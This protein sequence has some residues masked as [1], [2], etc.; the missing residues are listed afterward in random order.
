L[1]RLLGD[2]LIIPG[3]IMQ[4]SIGDKIKD[5]RKLTGRKQEDLANA[6]GVTPQAVSRW[7]ANGGYPDIEMIPSIANYFHIT[8]D[9]LFGYNNDRDRIIQ[10][11]NDK[12]QA[13]INKNDD[14]TECIALIRKGLEEFPDRVDFKT[15]LAHA[16]NMQGW[17]KNGEVPNIFWEEAAKLYE[18]LLAH[19]QSC[20]IPLISIYSMLG[21]H[22][23]AEKKASEQPDLELC[24]QVLLGNLGSVGSIN[25]DKRAEQYRGEAVLELLHTFQKSLGEAIACNAELM[26][27]QEGLE[28]LLLTRQLFEKIV[29]S[30]CYGFHS[31]LCFIDMQC[32]RIANNI[33]AYESAIDYFDSAFEHYIKFE[34]C[35][36][37]KQ[38]ELNDESRK[39]GNSDERFASSLLKSVNPAGFKVIVCEPKF[40]EMAVHS[41]PKEQKKL[42]KENPKYSCIFNC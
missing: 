21:K 42:I 27:S 22:E 17:K 5:L 14:M 36:N 19:D 41:F 24:R 37:I 39:N 35:K 25:D 15:K 3:I 40:L 4:V 30:E 8:I 7:E 33:G 34:Q 20:I 32:V 10:Q 31:D 18:E 23:K 2:D 28:L 13:L 29:G 12:A 9:E 11:Y 38:E 1:N 16:L 26:N 6:L